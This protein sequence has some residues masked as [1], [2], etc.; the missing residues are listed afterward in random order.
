MAAPPPSLETPDKSVSPF[1]SPPSSPRAKSPL[2]LRISP[3]EYNETGMV[4]AISPR[5]VTPNLS[6]RGRSPREDSTGQAKK[7]KSPKKHR[8]KKSKSKSRSPDRKKM[9]RYQ[10]LSDYNQDGVAVCKGDYVMVKRDHSET[11]QGHFWVRIRK[12][13]SEGWMPSA[14]LERKPLSSP[15]RPRKEVDVVS[16]AHGSPSMQRAKETP[17]L[18]TK[19]GTRKLVDHAKFCDT[20]GAAF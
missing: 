1:S 12:P 2:A 3:R 11:K 17:A 14:L 9:L 18:C 19:C 5:E 6:P 8:R 4:P 7:T 13:K 10:V 16:I 20:C 15:R